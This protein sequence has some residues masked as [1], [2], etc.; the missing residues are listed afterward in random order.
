MTAD[1][2][3]LAARDIYS[4]HV[5]SMFSKKTGRKR[6]IIDKDGKSFQVMDEVDTDF[7]ELN[8]FLN[9]DE[10]RSG[11]IRSGFFTDEHIKNLKLVNEVLARQRKRDI[12]SA[13]F[14]G[15]PTGL[16]I[17][18][19]I[20]RFYAVNRNVVSAR[21]VGTE[22]IIQALRMNN[23]RLLEEMFLNKDVA[24]AMADIIVK[25]QKLPEA[26]AIQI[27]N[28]LKAIAI[29]STVEYR[30][31]EREELAAEKLRFDLPK[32][33]QGLAGEMQQNLMGRDKYSPPQFMPFN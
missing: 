18:S 27:N 33:Q 16:S 8:K 13:K 31:T 17:E 23:H 19:Y 12:A 20:S 32:K 14:T 10:L 29:K 9:D 7:D 28:I 1:Q 15:Q 30:E 6:P 25:N 2:F 4:R 21:Y 22:S 26:R 24:E 5:R 11:M 3:N